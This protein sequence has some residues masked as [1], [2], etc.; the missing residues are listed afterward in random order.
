MAHAKPENKP[1]R[2]SLGQR[3]LPRSHGHGIASVNICNSRRDNDPASC[4]KQQAG[5][6]KRF[7]SRGLAEP[8][9]AVPELLQFAGGFLRLRS[10]MRSEERRVGKEWS[11]GRAR[12]QY[13]KSVL[14]VS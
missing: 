13:E 4:R 12:A 10:R 14:I 3:L 7:A 2:I 1:V 6:R 5:M 8:N 9:C 11:S